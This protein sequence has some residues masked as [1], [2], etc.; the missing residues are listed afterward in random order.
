MA[1]VNMKSNSFGGKNKDLREKY[2]QCHA[3]VSAIYLHKSHLPYFP[4]IC[5]IHCS[6]AHTTFSDL[7]PQASFPIMLRKTDNYREVSLTN[8]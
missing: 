3:I 5:T 2:P 7:M 4:A 6:F 1:K 8:G